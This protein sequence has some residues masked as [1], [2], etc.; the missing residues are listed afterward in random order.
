MLGADVAVLTLTS[1]VQYSDKVKPIC[2]P[3]NPGQNYVGKVA[4]ASGFGA[5]KYHKAQDNLMETKV[6]VISEEDC[7]NNIKQWREFLKTKMCTEGSPINPD[8]TTG[9]RERE[10]QGLPSTLKNMEGIKRRF[11]LNC[12]L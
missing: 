1:P 7:F 8:W 12:C 6:T 3:S 10:I 9:A 11:I 5:D 4:V 2:L